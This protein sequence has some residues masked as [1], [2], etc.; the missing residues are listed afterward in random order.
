MR[1]IVMAFLL[2]S[3][4]TS[5]CQNPRLSR[6]SSVLL[7][8]KFTFIKDMMDENSFR[9]IDKSYA[10]DKNYVYYINICDVGSAFEVLVETYYLIE[11]ADPKTFKVMKNKSFSRDKNHAYFEGFLIQGADPQTLQPLS[12]YYS[13]DN[14]H[15]F[16]KET[17]IDGVD[18]SSFR[19]IGDGFYGGAYDKNYLYYYHC[20]EKIDIETFVE[21]G[22]NICSDK[23]YIYH[24][25]GESISKRKNGS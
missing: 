20:K 24:L 2:M 4:I 22:S 23:N 6:K 8:D 25:S 9:K 5:F 14:N 18:L 10:K 3:S 7:T 21:N 13:K 17:K 11:N 16:F 1:I 19:L 12:M 15:V